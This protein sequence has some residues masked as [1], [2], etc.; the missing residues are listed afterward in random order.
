MF[1]DKNISPLEFTNSESLKVTVCFQ[2]WAT[3][4]A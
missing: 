4:I 1:D 2:Q 3:Y